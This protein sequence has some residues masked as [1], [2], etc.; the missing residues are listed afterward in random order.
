MFMDTL[1]LAV[2]FMIEMSLMPSGDLFRLIK[3]SFGELESSTSSLSSFSIGMNPRFF[4][5]EPECFWVRGG[6][7][8]LSY[9]TSLSIAT[10]GFSTNG[11]R[12]LLSIFLFF[13]AASRY[14]ML[15]F[16]STLSANRI[17]T[18]FWASS[19]CSMTAFLSRLN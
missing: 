18:D 16:Y 3:L 7:D 9:F 4:L 17:Y 10:S 19:F 15:S 1:V 8:M 14:A 11:C 6:G 2:L 5:A 13:L 12:T